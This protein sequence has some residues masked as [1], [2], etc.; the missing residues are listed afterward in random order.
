VTLGTWGVDPP[1]QDRV[2]F[3]CE[4]RLIGAMA[5]DA[6]V[7]LNGTPQILGTRL[8]REQALAHPRRDLFWAVVDAISEQDPLILS[9]VYDDR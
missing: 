7:S 9:T 6:P 3:A 4:L 5:L 8:T 2:T 1:A